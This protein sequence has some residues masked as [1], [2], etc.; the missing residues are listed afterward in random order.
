MSHLD[1]HVFICRQDNYGVLVHDNKSGATASIDAP[2]ATVIEQQLMKRGWQLT[3]IFTTHHHGDHVEGNLHLKK[4]F[5]CAIIGPAAEADRI[6]GIGQPVK[7]GDTFKFAGRDVHVIATPGHT[8]GH[9][10]YH[11][12]SEFSA[13]VGDTLFSLGCGRVI[14]GTMEEMCTSL[15]TL[16]KLPPHTHLFSGHEYTEA[17]A[18]FAL[19]VEPGNRALRQRAEMVSRQR[20]NGEFTVPS[21]L[22]DEIRTNPFLRWDSPEIRALLGMEQASDTEVFTEIRKRKNAFK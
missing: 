21:I 17:N 3:H 12:P 8:K 4:Q 19:T 13:F 18:R 7:G 9:I 15:A 11:I 6:P 14:E 2:E 10:A 1:T 16:R 20:A 5:G 22:S